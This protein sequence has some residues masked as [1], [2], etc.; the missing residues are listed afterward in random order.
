[1]DWNSQ[2]D[3]EQIYIDGGVVIWMLNVLED[4]SL[5]DLIRGQLSEKKKIKDLFINVIK[6][7]DI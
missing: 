5:N 6:S 3:K 4:G 2:K 1:M 7:L